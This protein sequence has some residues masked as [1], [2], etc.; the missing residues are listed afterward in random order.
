MRITSILTG[1]ALC[2][3]AA[4]SAQDVMP[5]PET[6]S[7]PPVRVKLTSLGAPGT[8]TISVTG[9]ARLLDSQGVE[10]LI[11]GSSVVISSVPG[12]LAAAG[13]TS[14]GFRVEAE[15]LRVKAGR[16]ERS[17]PEALIV[18][19]AGS[20][21]SLTNECSLEE[22]TAGVL[23][24]ECP[25]LFHPQAIRANA[26]AIRSYSFR[27]AYL[28]PAARGPLCDTTHCQVYTG[29]EA[30]RPAHSQAVADTAGLVCMYE[31]EVIEAVYS[32]D[33]GGR[34]EANEAA[35]EGARPIPYLRPVQDAP[36]EGG[37]SFCAVN[38]THRWSVK[39]TESDL[40]NLGGGEPLELA[41]VEVTPGGRA[42]RVQ[43]GVGA[44]IFKGDEWRRRLGMS[45]LRS[46]KFDVAPAEGGV[47]LKGAGYGH[48]VGLC[49]FGAN[50]QGRAGRDFVQILGHYYSETVVGPAPS[51]E[52]QLARLE[53]IR[54]AARLAARG[55]Q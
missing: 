37:V 4:A 12:G 46:L 38:R 33:C 31:G 42:K 23:A 34:T 52:Q 51:V 50:G 45:R 55:M 47:E 1:L 28:A 3:V 16:T 32:A 20:G 19:R 13:R 17:Y 48:G 9:P 30:I 22:Y 49:Q 18:S 54:L 44:R 36:E 6:A 21:L 7:L 24:R 14:A 27:R 29:L 39:L 2:C 35:W 11:E 26:V 25:A 8:I 5:A 10:S 41:V 40:K 53:E 15:K 43:V